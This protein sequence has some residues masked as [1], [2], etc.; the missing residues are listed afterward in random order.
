LSVLCSSFPRQRPRR[1]QSSNGVCSIVEWY[2][3]CSTVMSN[4]SEA[5]TETVMISGFPGNLLLVWL[6]LKMLHMENAPQED[7]MKKTVLIALLLLIG[8]ALAFPQPGYSWGHR[9]YGPGVVVGTAAAVVGAGAALL[10]AV[11]GGPGYGYSGPPAAYGYPPP[12]YG[13]PA[14]AYG[15]SY[16]GPRYYSAGY[17]YR[18]YYAGRGRYG[19]RW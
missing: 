18:G 19:R 2:Q 8:M 3:S 16:Y 15:Y 7:I 10:G 9:W 4:P 17:G 6:L 14:P 13:Y 11:I 12:T 1:R 5:R